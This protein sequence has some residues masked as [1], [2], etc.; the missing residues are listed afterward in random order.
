MINFRTTDGNVPE[1]NIEFTRNFLKMENI[2]VISNNIGGSYGR[3][4]L[5]F[6]DTGKV[7]MKKIEMLDSGILSM[8]KLMV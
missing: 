8:K 5:F 2:K 7:L 3:K 6:P 4:V 1:Q